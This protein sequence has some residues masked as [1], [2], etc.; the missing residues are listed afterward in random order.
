MLAHNVYFTLK[1]N[2]DPARQTLVEGCKK[3]LTDHPGTKSF[4]VGTLAEGLE[5]P[6]N[7]RD[8]DV[9]LHIIFESRQAHD[10]YQ[11]HARHIEFVEQHQDNWE[12]ARVFDTDL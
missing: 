10:D 4:A 2:S 1:D 6:V 8:F 3:Y 12:R 11:K 5:R 7:V 9:G